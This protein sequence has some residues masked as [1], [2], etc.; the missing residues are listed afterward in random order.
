MGIFIGSMIIKWVREAIE[1]LNIKPT[2]ITIT[3]L[4]ENHVPLAGWYVVHA[5]PVKWSVSG[6][7]AQESSIVLETI[8]FQYNYFK[9]LSI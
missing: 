7:N 5:Y 6:F 4:N 1:N 2:N 9:S 3:L 8:Q